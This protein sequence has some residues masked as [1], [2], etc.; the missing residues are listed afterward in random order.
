MNYICFVVPLGSIPEL[1]AESCHEIKAS[2]GGQ[3][4]SGTYW[5]SSIIPDKVALAYCDM[6]TEG[7]FNLSNSLFVS[8][9][10]GGQLPTQGK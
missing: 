8:L 5:F 6:K 1:P 2:E 4:V 10:C 3:T 9:F 7:N